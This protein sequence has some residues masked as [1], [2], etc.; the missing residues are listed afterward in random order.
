[1]PALVDDADLPAANAIL[2]GLRQG[3]EVLGPLLG[4]LIVAAGGVRA[5]LAVDAL[6]F[7]VSVP[8]LLRLPRMPAS[9]AP[10]PASA[11]T[12]SP[13]SATPSASHW[14]GT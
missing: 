7:L 8:L 10:A 1:M 5:G 9:P 6:T 14:S 4:G 2:S 13:A 3:G 11:P 12:P